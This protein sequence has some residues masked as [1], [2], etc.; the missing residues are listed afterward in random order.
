[1][2]DIEEAG[3]RPCMEVFFEDTIAVVQRHLIAGER[4]HVAAEFK[5]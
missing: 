4:H 1:V 3:R 2:R 5:M